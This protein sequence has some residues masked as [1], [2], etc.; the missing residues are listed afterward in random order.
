MKNRKKTDQTIKDGKYA[1]LI[2]EI[3]EHIYQDNIKSTDRR[4]IVIFPDGN[5]REIDL[6]VTLKNGQEIAFEVRD[7]RGNQG[8]D[9][10]DKVIGKYKNTHFS[11]IWICT[12][13]DCNLSKNAI[14]SL[15]YNNIGW[16]NININ[17]ED[18]SNKPVLFINA[19]K[20][21][22][23]DSEMYI[24]GEK[25]QELIL[26]C[27]NQRGKSFDVSLRKKILQDIKSILETNFD[28][29][30]DHNS[31]DY[32]TTIDL[33]SLP[34]NLGKSTLEIKIKLP[35]VHYSFYDYF[36]ENYVISNDDKE[37]YLLAT[38]NKS[39]FIT[40]NCI[41]I[42]FSFLSNLRNKGYIISNHFLTDMTVIPKKYR[43]KN[44]IRII[45]VDGNSQD[46]LM[47]I[48]GYK[49]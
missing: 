16:R 14:R 2:N 19:I 22:D 43:N 39:F 12:F 15:K 21:I 38:K 37:N 9:W 11:K 3:A 17:D 46:T 36:S 29:Y 25:Y 10:V 27:M 48:V 31:I 42:N 34:T 7:R 41:V 6:L 8:I 26:K 32:K 40:D 13:G 24:N 1:E 49:K 47:K 44:K 33:G 23:D 18:I 4:A 35:L 5:K 45:D 20:T 30:L 28:N